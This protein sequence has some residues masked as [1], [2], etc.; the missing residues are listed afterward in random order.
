M[1]GPHVHDV[2]LV[3]RRAICYADREERARVVGGGD[4]LRVEQQGPPAKSNVNVY[5]SFADYSK[6]MNCTLIFFA[7]NCTVVLMY[8]NK[9]GRSFGT[10]VFDLFCGCFISYH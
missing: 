3:A 9:C 1:T 4:E 2:D 6:R 5:L 8:L 7:E 10:F